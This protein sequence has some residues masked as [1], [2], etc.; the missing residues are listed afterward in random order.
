MQEKYV[1]RLIEKK[2]QEIWAERKSFAM[3]R[4]IRKPKKYILEMWP[5]PS[6]HLHMG[7]VRNYLLGDV[8]ARYYRMRGFDVVH[9]MGWDAF[10]LPA[11]NAAIKDGVHPAIRTRENIA[12]IKSAIVS[13]GYSYDW[14][15]EATSCDP[16]YYRW[17]QWFFLKMREMGL[18]YRRFSR[19]NWCGVSLNGSTPCLTVIANE[20]V[21]DG[22]CERCESKVVDKEMPEWAFRITKYSAELLDALDGL[23]AWP[24][25]IISAQRMWI[26]RSAG[27]EV[28]FKVEGHDGSIRIFTTRLDTIFGCTYLVVAPDE[29]SVRLSTSAQRPAVQAFVDAM[30]AKSKTERTAEGAEKNGVFTGGYARNPFNGRLIPIFVANF[31]LSDYGTGAVMGVPGHDA[32]DHEFAVKFGLPI[33]DVI[34]SPDRDADEGSLFTGEGTLVRSGDY[35]GLTSA[36]ARMA[37]TAWLVSEGIGA[38]SVTWRQK[39]WGF[40]RQRYWGTPIP[41]IYCDECDPEKQGISVPFEQL[42]VLLPDIE[43]DKVLTGKGEPPL[44]KVPAFVNAPCPKCGKMGRREVETMDTFV[45][46][47]WYFGR[48]LSPGFDGAPFEVAKAKRYLP[49]DV[50]VGGPEHAVMHLLYFRFWT[51]VMK[52]LGLC[53]IDEPIT[54]LVTQGIVNG[55]DGRKMSKR[56]GN[57]VSSL[58]LVE[59]VGADAARMYV[60]FAGPPERD[61]NWSDAQVDGASRFLRRVWALAYALRGAGTAPKS[62]VGRVLAMQRATHK[63]IQRITTAIERLSFNTAISAA[64]EFVN[65]LYAVAE[66]HTPDE[67]A[68]LRASIRTLCVLLTPFTPHFA[69]EVAEAYGEKVP[70][71]EHGWPTFDPELVEDDVIPYAVQVMGKLRG[72]VMAPRDATEAQV[73]E[74][75]M[76]D[77]KVTAVLSGRAIRKFVFVPKRLVNLVVD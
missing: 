11:E 6:G 38:A 55:H 36:A 60:L 70:L 20:Q 5:Y 12:S 49:V 63:T 69:N 75:V 42:P 28:D 72:E 58:D 57:V 43:V 7:H 10:G 8:L 50:Y 67:V 53:E 61:F 32:R 41:I 30:A 23:T 46:S 54:R 52:Q 9:P 2:W 47:S 4:D 65:T 15:L 3:G 14:A 37:M 68:Q 18:V 25:R 26:G 77:T 29:R 33:V 74:L 40:S 21:T 71:E 66:P 34:A 48:Y 73:R 64:M 56:W 76:A 62:A 17:N 27:A 59:R 1:P 39:D 35:D 19:V 16:D 31:V 45:D 22:V 51:R 24:D 13:L 44:A